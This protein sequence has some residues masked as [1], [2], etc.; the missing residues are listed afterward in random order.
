VWKASECFGPGIWKTIFSLAPVATTI[1]L[2]G[3]SG[4]PGS[5]FGF[6]ADDDP[7]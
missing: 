4:R 1:L 2:S 6:V 3:L 7:G 5:I